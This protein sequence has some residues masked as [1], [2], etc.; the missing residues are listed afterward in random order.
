[1]NEGKK[2]SITGNDYM[3]LSTTRGGKRACNCNTGVVDG[4]VRSVQHSDSV[5][6]S[7]LYIA[8]K[9]PKSSDSS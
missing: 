9:S 1:M 3:C 2:L 7:P 5:K 6:V 8:E 4:T